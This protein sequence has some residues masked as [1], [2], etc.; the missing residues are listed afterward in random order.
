VVF[1]DGL[2]WI[3]VSNIKAT[4]EKDNELKRSNREVRCQKVFDYVT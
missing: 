4:T 3:S 1:P 2:I